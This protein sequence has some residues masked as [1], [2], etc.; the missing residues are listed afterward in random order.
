VS[1]R[2]RVASWP[3]KFGSVARRKNCFKRYAIARADGSDPDTPPHME[4]RRGS[5]LRS[6]TAKPTMK[7]EDRR[8][9]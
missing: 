4:I 1:R 5:H 7:I 9:A 3:D 6:L 8:F 2:G